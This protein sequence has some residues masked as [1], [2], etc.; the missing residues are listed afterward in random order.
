MNFIA[1]L[2]KQHPRSPDEHLTIH[3]NHHPRQPSLAQ[4]LVQPCAAAPQLLSLGS[5]RCSH[6]VRPKFH[7]VLIFAA[8]LCPGCA[9]HYEG[10]RITPASRADIP[11]FVAAIDT[12]AK[13]LGFQRFKPV[14]GVE[15]IS[16]IG[17]PSV[18]TT[19]Q[20]DTLRGY[21]VGLYSTTADFRASYEPHTNSF[22]VFAA[23]EH[24]RP[25]DLQRRDVLLARAVEQIRLSFPADHIFL[26]RH[27][28]PIQFEG[29]PLPTHPIN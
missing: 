5:S 8:L 23:I 16:F 15:Q 19:Y 7:T 27:E 4:R 18:G 21:L 11:K 9:Q 17:G 24:A 29:V 14:E 6:L 28:N 26:W 22:T 20:R 13:Q 2:P 12:T 10:L 25:Q 3:K 1:S